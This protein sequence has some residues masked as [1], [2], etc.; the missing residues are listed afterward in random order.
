M[1]KVEYRCF[2][3]LNISEIGEKW[4]DN[5]S[6]Y[7]PV[8]VFYQENGLRSYLDC[9]GTGVDTVSDPPALYEGYRFY[10]FYQFDIWVEKAKDYMTPF[11]YAFIMGYFDKY[12]IAGDT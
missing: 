2:D 3:P 12:G 9:S 7:G 8:K 4:A 11:Q 1:R 5:E 10:P 6:M